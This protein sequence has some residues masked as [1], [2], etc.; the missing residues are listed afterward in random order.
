MRIQPDSSPNTFYKNVLL[1]RKKLVIRGYNLGRYDYIFKACAFS[2]KTRVLQEKLKD[3]VPTPRVFHV[4]S[5]YVLG[6]KHGLQQRIFN[7]GLHIVQSVFQKRGLERPS[8][9]IASSIGPN[10]F[11]RLYRLT[12]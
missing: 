9:R 1:F 5:K 11:R 3:G 10:M 12:W 8:I 7:R 4:K 6:A 2:K